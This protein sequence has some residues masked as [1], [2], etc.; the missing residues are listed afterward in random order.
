MGI[1]VIVALAPGD[2]N[3]ALAE[4]IGGQDSDAAGPVGGRRP[5]PAGSIPV[6]DTIYPPASAA[7]L[8]SGPVALTDGRVVAGRTDMAIET[9][10]VKNLI[11]DD[12]RQLEFNDPKT[13]KLLRYNLFMPIDYEAGKSYPLVLFMHDAGATSDVTRTTLFQGLDAI[14]WATPQ[15]QKKHPAFV[16]APQFAEI[17]VDNDSRASNALDATINTEDGRRMNC[18]PRLTRST[19]KRA[20]STM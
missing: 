16:L 8:Q 4:K 12:F 10:K 19:L 5:G 1:F 3:A 11:V 20:Q 9:T 17:I 2:A 18:A 14:S 7:I 15:D 6:Y 13:G